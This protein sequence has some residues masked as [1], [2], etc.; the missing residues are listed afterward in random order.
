MK[1]DKLEKFITKYNLGG[2]CNQAILNYKS[3]NLMTSFKTDHNDLMGMVMV[4][5]CN[6]DIDDIE[7]GVFN[8]GLLSNVLSAMQTEINISFNTE[9]G[10]ASS[11][12]ISDEIMKSQVILADLDIMDSSPTIKQLPDFTDEISIN[13]VF[14][15]RFIKARNAISDADT[16]AIIKEGSDIRLV[17]NYSEN[18]NTDRI[19]ITLSEE[20]NSDTDYIIYFK[21]DSIKKLLTANKDATSGKLSISPEGLMMV[22]LVGEDFKVKYYAVMLQM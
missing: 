9:G 8:T 21:S 1:K 10:K 4:S 5:D 14:I 17:F 15:D 7:F 19:G 18:Q 16:F 20:S 22:D 6:I 2:L 11:L 12:D 13:G 3:G